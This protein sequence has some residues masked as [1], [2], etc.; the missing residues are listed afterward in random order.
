[1]INTQDFFLNFQN[2]W[3]NGKMILIVNTALT[4]TDA[5]DQQHPHT[6][7]LQH[8]CV[9]LPARSRDRLGY[10]GSRRRLVALVKNSG[11]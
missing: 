6:V 3:V 10:L 8:G 2:Y 5:A 4:I 9:G 1:M 7:F 11:T